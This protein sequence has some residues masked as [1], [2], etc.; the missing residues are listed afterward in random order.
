MSLAGHKSGHQTDE[1]PFMTSSASC[2]A[3]SHLWQQARSWDGAY[4]L[5][6]LVASRTT[7]RRRVRKSFTPIA[8]KVDIE[9]FSVHRENAICG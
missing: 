8:C 2:R 5:E 7:Y 9:N 4:T 6:G 3:R 1:P